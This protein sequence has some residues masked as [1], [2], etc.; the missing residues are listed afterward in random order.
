MGYTATG[1]ADSTPMATHSTV[2]RQEALAE[3]HCLARKIDI[4]DRV[5]SKTIVYR[6]RLLFRG[7]L[8]VHPALPI[9]AGRG[10]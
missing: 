7:V 3:L 4:L 8:L 2:K 5:R 6:I 10:S 9:P 1:Q